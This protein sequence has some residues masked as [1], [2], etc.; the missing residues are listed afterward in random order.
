MN[1]KLVNGLLLLSIATVGCGTFTSCKDTDDDIKSDLIGQQNALAANLQ[2]QI[3]ALKAQIAGIKSCDCDLTPIKNQ[4]STIESWLNIAEG[5]ASLNDRI[6]R[7]IE[8]SKIPVDLTEIEKAIKDLQD[9]KAD[10]SALKEL[11]DKLDEDVANLQEQID[12]IVE[13]LNALITSIENNQAYNL[14]FGTLN[15]PVGLQSQILGSYY[16]KS[17]SAI[18][19]PL[20][21][22]APIE[23]NDQDA[24]DQAIQDL[25]ASG[26]AVPFG[27]TNIPAGTV[28][29]EN[30]E[31]NLGQLYTTINPNNIDFTGTD[32]KLVTSDGKEAPIT[33]KAGKTD[34]VLNFGWTRADD[35]VGIYRVNASINPAD[36]EAIALHLDANFKSAVKDALK[37]PGKQTIA[38][39]GKALLDQMDGFLPA[40]AVKAP[41]T[42]N[43][44][45]YAAYS[46]FEIAATAIHPLGYET[47]SD[48]TI[49]HELPTFGPLSETL[50]RFFDD[51]K[52]D[53]T[54]D[55]GLTPI[56]KINIDLNLDDFKISAD[57]IVFTIPPVPVRDK[58]KDI[59]GTSDETKVVLTYNPDGTVSAK[60]DALN[61]LVNAIVEAVNDYINGDKGL[62]ATINEQLI[63]QVNDKIIDNLNSQ[64]MGMQQKIDDSLASIV[65]KIHNQL[66]GKLGSAEKILDKYNALAEK[67]N[68]MLKDPNH[69]LQVAMAYETTNDGLHMLSSDVNDPS[70][71]KAGNGNAI[72]LFASSLTGEIAAP[73][74]QK[75]IAVAKATKLADGSNDTAAVAKANGTLNKVIPGRQQIVA[76][77]GLQ[78]GYKYE[79]VYTS[80]D[81]RGRTST[82]IFYLQVI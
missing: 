33:L 25:E 8:D 23:V 76:L 19:F 22:T 59:I 58:D 45:N 44:E 68:Q 72:K 9:N 28:Y 18:D 38:Q 6:M 26:V 70:I 42:V 78:S 52:A 73:S 27:Y 15:L 75:Y 16:G 80:L 24:V 29:M 66:A 49:S 77:S 4:L 7:L 5:D 3:D 41:W 64:L 79:I 56:E 34:E 14:F 37:N 61:P 46:K 21:K 82:R 31:N 65:D 50:D 60:E 67:I 81:Y 36:V 57:S 12:A 55:L 30:I 39:V 40:Y 2:K 63:A 74:Y 43:E 53:I 1:R 47:L 48:V 13:R 54:I 11:S 17:A 51:L 32:L 71:F 69:Y 20:S 35:A 62:I 10:A